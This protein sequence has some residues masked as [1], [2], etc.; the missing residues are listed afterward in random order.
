MKKPTANILV[1]G[2]TGL[3]GKL[4]IKEFEKQGIPVRALIRDREKA[5]AMESY[6]QVSI[7]EG[8]MLQPETLHAALE[9]VEK[10]LMIS[11]A[12][13]EMVAT[14]QSFTDAAKKAGVAHV[15]KYSGADSGIGFNSQNFIAQKE[16]ENAE[17]NLVHSGLQWTLL[18]PSQFMQMYLPGAPAGV[19]MQQDE[20]V[21][22][23]G[24]G[25][26]SPV[27]IE[28]VAKVCVQL[29][30]QDGHVNR[31]YEMTGPDAL[32]ME[33]ACEILTR[34]TGR[35]MRHNNLSFEA[36]ESLLVSRGLP[37][38]N[39]RILI[40]IARERSKCIESHIKLD[41]H[42]RFGIRPTNFAEFIYKNISAFGP[43]SNK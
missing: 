22:P 7:Y 17:D 12:A 36:Y 43:F 31:I 1:T 40:E 19:N 3:S 5:K 14:Q 25:K 28:D 35:K 18:R 29:L 24:Q 33:E 41:T 32:N 30:T 38:K 13:K 6:T 15:I 10:V 4:V 23:I 16:H 9:G 42:K 8:D 21:L 37:A 34:V 39:M 2:A 27:D 20:L 11:S 26:L